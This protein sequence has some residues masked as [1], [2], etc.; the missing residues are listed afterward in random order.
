MECRKT[1]PEKKE[2]LKRKK[3]EF[4]EKS[5]GT[6]ETNK[7]ETAAIRYIHLKCKKQTNKK[8]YSEV[9]FLLCC[10]KAGQLP[11]RF[12]RVWSGQ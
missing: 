1:K 11:S 12:S 8:K 3:T 6:W 10:I 7:T 4:G 2:I 9:L 5:N